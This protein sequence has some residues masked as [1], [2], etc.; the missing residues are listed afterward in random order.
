M[1]P[2]CRNVILKIAKGVLH[3]V[4]MC[5]N[6]PV[7]RRI[8]DALLRSLLW[9]Q[10]TP[11]AGT[12]VSSAHILFLFYYAAHLWNI[13]GKSRIKI[14]RRLEL[15]QAQN[16][17][18][19]NCNLGE[20][21]REHEI[22]VTTNNWTARKRK[23]SESVTVP[24][25]FDDPNYSGLTHCR[26]DLLLFSGCSDKDVGAAV[27]WKFAVRLC[28]SSAWRP[29]GFKPLRAVESTGGWGAWG[30]ERGGG[31]GGGAAGFTAL[32]PGPKHIMIQSKSGL[33]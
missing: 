20:S 14:K 12:P 3:L 9:G 1:T 29:T 31:V 15:R 16:L 27:A 10:V 4:N 11:A 17:L 24:A 23:I 6:K 33:T 32:A 22:S 5:V 21:P 26:R 18:G 19:E 13:A 8:V 30:Q 2:L 25:K 28:L 7:K